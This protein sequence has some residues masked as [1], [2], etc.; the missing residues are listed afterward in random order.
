MDEAVPATQE[1]APTTDLRYQQRRIDFQF[2]G[3]GSEFFRI[4]IVNLVLTILTLGI[5]SAWAKVRT[6]RYF[7]GS[8][9][10]DGD[11]FD[12]LANPIA[13][14]KGRLIAVAALIVYTVSQTLFPIASIVLF[15]V[16]IAV[17]PWIVVRALRFNAIM[18]SWRGIRFG[19]DG[20]PGEA[21]IVFI[22]WALFGIITLGFGMP[23]AWYK[24]NHYMLPNYRFGQT[25]ARTTT[26]P[27]DFYAIFFALVG[28]GIGGAI[29]IA[30]IVAGATEFTDFTD[31]SSGESAE[32][33]ILVIA[34]LATLYFIYY[35]GLYVI[36]EVLYF[37]TVYK[38]IVLGSNVLG[39]NALDTDV[40]IIAWF[41]VLIV[42]TMGMILTLGLFYPWARVRMTRYIFSHLWVNATDLDSFV[43]RQGDSEN[44][45]G[46]EIGEA[47]DLGIGI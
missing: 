18:S 21:A 44:A 11:R 45:L 37:S 27:G 31:S 20:S 22:G 47:F 34:V 46:E 43:A 16:F 2:F 5:Y 32:L 24:Q 30:L 26:T 33:P 8:T 17:L 1:S 38:N 29:V 41:K 7:Y 36:Y 6:K 39:S 3:D 28:A 35:I 15:I 42:N 14:L 9:E 40:T 25:R 10:L 13:I 12:Y 4:W 23:Y 19:F